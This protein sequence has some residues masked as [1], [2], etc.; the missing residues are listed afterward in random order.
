[1]VAVVADAGN[2]VEGGIVRMEFELRSVVAVGRAAWLESLS[3]ARFEQTCSDAGDAGE[4]VVRMPPV[5]LDLAWTSSAEGTFVESASVRMTETLTLPD[6]YRPGPVQQTS[7][8]SLA[9]L[10]TPHAWSP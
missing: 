5:M 2:E 3:G 4:L 1:M 9:T 8:S 10:D 6:W 7:S